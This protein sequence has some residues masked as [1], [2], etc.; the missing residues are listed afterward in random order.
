MVN[1]GT[2]ATFRVESDLWEQFK[3]RATENRY[4]ASALLLQFVED[5]VLGNVPDA[6]DGNTRIDNLDRRIDGLDERLYN[7]EKR[8]D[9]GNQADCIDGVD[10][11]LDMGV[12]RAE[13]LDKNSE[14]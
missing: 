7:L 5:Y 4:S 8:L 9:T 6:I 13:C 12:A 3:A 1:K 11:H 10:K 2:L 14:V